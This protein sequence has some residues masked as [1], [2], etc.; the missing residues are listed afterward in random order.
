MT[1]NPIAHHGHNLWNV[2]GHENERGENLKKNLLK[3]VLTYYFVQLTLPLGI[4]TGRL[5]IFIFLEFQ[6]FLKKRIYE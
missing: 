5:W 3:D 4:S 2:E 6:I 1:C